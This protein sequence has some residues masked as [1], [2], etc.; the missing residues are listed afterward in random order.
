MIDETQKTAYDM[1]YLSVCAIN[2][3]KPSKEKLENIDLNAVFLLCRKH[4]L[5]SLVYTAVRDCVNIPIWK[6][7][8]FKALRKNTMLDLARNQLTDWL[9]EKG[10]W[11]MTLKGAVIKDLYPEPCM[12]QMSDND[13]LYD[14]KYRY[15]VKD[16]FVSNGYSAELYDY[17]NQDVYKKK[18]VLNFEMHRS[19]F[20]KEQNEIFYDY[21]GNVLSRLKPS[22]EGTAFEFS[23][24]DFYI[25]I[26]AHEFNH[27]SQSGT[28]LRSLI[29]RY[30]YMKAKGDALDRDYICGE[31]KKIEIADYE[32][33]TMR[34]IQRV[35]NEKAELTENDREELAPYLFDGLYGSMA[36][37]LKSKIISNSKDGKIT[38]WAK[39][40]NIFKILFPDIIKMRK[41]CEVNCPKLNKPILLPFA[42]LYRIISDIFKY[43]DELKKMIKR[44]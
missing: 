18:P 19:L 12:R 1:L 42:Y 43:R 33:K 35:F 37:Y 27:F 4:G 3:E 38:V 11:H 20:P 13:I 36:N 5:L 39:I 44:K 23:D 6:E 34:L 29:D 24:N 40:K 22:G 25:Y 21:Y 17:T 15:E 8:Y 31:L 10:I 28:G 30:V 7:E 14:E 41:W 16:W 2:Q 32:E 26:V 9:S